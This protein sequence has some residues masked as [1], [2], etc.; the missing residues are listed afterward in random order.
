MTDQVESKPA[1]YQGFSIG[2]IVVLIGAVITLA[3]YLLTWWEKADEGVTVSGLGNVSPHT[4]EFHSGKLHWAALAGAI[5]LIIVAVAR[6]IGKYTDEWQKA[7][8]FA[9]AAAL[10][11]AGYALFAPAGE[12]FST[13]TGVYVVTAGAVIAAAGAA[14][15]AFAKR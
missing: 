11:G 4:Y 15:I 9:T 10:V 14:L 3:S 7:T 5:V 6:L 2:A 12:G 8:V 1:V 13:T